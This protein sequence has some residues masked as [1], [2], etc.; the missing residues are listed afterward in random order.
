MERLEQKL[1]D[2]RA[3]I[4]AHKSRLAI[5][6]NRW[7]AGMENGDCAKFIDSCIRVIDLQVKK[8]EQQKGAAWGEVDTTSVTEG[9]A[10]KARLKL[11]CDDN[12]KN[13]TNVEYWKTALIEICKE[14]AP[15][16]EPDQHRKL[17]L[18]CDNVNRMK[19]TR[20]KVARWYD[21]TYHPHKKAKQE[22]GAE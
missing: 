10:L 19:S 22:D 14:I 9:E 5:A 2:A 3:D 1:I 17:T 18:I 6:F 15:H 12:L 21:E 13:P 11:F 4:K 8:M 20:K 7:S 16:V